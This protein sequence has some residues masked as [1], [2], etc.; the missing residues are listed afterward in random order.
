MSVSE[1][2][3]MVLQMFKE[4]QAEASGIK[5]PAGA[6]VFFRGIPVRWLMA[7]EQEILCLDD[8]AAQTMKWDGE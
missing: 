8:R 3:R 6:E 2:L 4:W 5:V 7:H 1:D